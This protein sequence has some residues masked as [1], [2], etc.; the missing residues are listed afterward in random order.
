MDVMIAFSEGGDLHCYRL[1]CVAWSFSGS[2]WCRYQ[3]CKPGSSL[4]FSAALPAVTGTKQWERP[5]GACALVH[6]SESSHMQPRGMQPASVAAAE[7]ASNR[8]RQA[9]G[10]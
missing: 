6:Y 1:E 3:D 2:S 8:A 7:A 4:C 9:V 5:E 10:A